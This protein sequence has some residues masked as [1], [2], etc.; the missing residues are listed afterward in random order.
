MIETYTN[1]TWS[2]YLSQM[3]FGVSVRLE[4]KWL[5]DCRLLMLRQAEFILKDDLS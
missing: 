3:R 1:T 5:V 4:H 2:S